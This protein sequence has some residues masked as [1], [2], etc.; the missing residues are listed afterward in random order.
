MRT[1]VEISDAHRAKLLRLAAER[2]EKGFSSLV[3]KALDAYLSAAG[4]R[5]DRIKN[6]LALEATFDSETS[7]VIEASIHRLRGTWR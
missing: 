4:D 5:K 6:A 3:A 7:D 2:G 1:T